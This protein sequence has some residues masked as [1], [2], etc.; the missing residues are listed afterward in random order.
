MIS[1]ATF[2]A[3]AVKKLDRLGAKEFARQL[4]IAL[5]TVLQIAGIELL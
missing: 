5:A 1:Q 2:G 4:K 3:R